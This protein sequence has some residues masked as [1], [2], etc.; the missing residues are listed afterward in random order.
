MIWFYL[1]EALDSFLKF[2]WLEKLKKTLKNSHLINIPENP[3]LL[4][5]CSWDVIEYGL[6][7]QDSYVSELFALNN[8]LLI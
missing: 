6:F 5:F 3:N 8:N 1:I 2:I 4:L 7:M